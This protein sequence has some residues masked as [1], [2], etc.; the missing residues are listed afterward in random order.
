MNVL[1]AATFCEL[2]VGSIPSQIGLYVAVKNH[3][4]QSVKFGLLYYYLIGQA[5]VNTLQIH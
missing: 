4:V 1:K 2:I 3:K 5:K